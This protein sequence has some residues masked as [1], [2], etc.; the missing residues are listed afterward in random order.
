M[1]DRK[2]YKYLYPNKDIHD[3][4]K[5]LVDNLQWKGKLLVFTNHARREFEELGKPIELALDILIGGKHF[6][7]SKKHNKFNV[8]YPYKNK[9]LCMSYVEQEDIILVHIKP[10]NKRVIK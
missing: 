9:N 8:F 3:V 2:I 10:T 4:D 1:N 6:L 7:V 5:I